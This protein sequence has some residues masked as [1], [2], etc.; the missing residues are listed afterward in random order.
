MGC[1]EVAIKRIRGR[2]L[3]RPFPRELDDTSSFT[4]FYLKKY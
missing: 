4:Q 3:A 1:S 2:R